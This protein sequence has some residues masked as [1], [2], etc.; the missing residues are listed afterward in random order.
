MKV[1]V[2]EWELYNNGILVCEWFDL[3][4]ITIDEIETYVSLIKGK[5][6]L[7]TEDLELFVADIEDDELNLFVNEESLT[8]AYEVQ[9]Q[10]ENI[11]KENYEPIA[12]MLNAGIVSDLEE[13]IEYLDDIHST[14]ESKMEDVAYNYVQDSGLL[15][16]M[17]ASIQCYFD[18]QAL[19]RDMDINGTYLEADDGILWE[20]A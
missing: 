1:A 16:G 19:G 4:E 12:L 5:H 10:L 17:P 9:E 18:Y 8:L 20:V 11:D 2:E 13:A 14:G 7:N 15:D 3:A 6:G